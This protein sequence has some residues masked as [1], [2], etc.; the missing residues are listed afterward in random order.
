MAID[1]AHARYFV[2]QLSAHDISGSC[3]TLGRQDIYFTLEEICSLGIEYKVPGLRQVANRTEIS[4]DNQLYRVIQEN[5]HLAIKTEHR[6]RQ[7]ISDHAFFGMMGFDMV[8]S[9]DIQDHD[10]PVYVFDLNKL[11][12]EQVASRQYDLVVNGGTLEHIFHLPNALRNIHMVLKPG[13]C[14]IHTAPIHNYVDHGFYTFSPILFHAWYEANSYEILDMTIYRHT[15]NPSV[16]PWESFP[17]NPKSFQSLSFGG[18][19]GMMY[20]VNVMARKHKNS[21]C[22]VSPIQP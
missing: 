3:L 14:V 15:T 20:M 12:L 21:T 13:G 6:T 9:L 16:D 10:S 4:Q 8:E 1:G 19:D 11:G 22:D 18:L 5:R 7:L 2:S 17:Y